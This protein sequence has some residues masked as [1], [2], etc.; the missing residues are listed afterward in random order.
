MLFR[1]PKGASLRSL[2]FV[3]L[4]AFFLVLDDIMDDSHTRRGRPCWFRVPQVSEEL[5]HSEYYSV[6]SL[7][8]KSVY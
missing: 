7:T 2:L 5:V 3:Q 8:Q 4:Q 6:C 1:K